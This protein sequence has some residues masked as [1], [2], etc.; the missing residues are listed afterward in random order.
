MQ[1][2]KEQ[3]LSRLAECETSAD[4]HNLYE[5]VFKEEVPEQFK[6]DPNEILDDII[7][8]IYDNKKIIGVD[9]PD[10]TLI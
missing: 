8:A 1:I 4:F 7:N 5:I 2:T 9:L 10:N 3:R 6:R